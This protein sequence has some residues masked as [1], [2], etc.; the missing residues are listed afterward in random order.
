MKYLV[1]AQ[2][3]GPISIDYSRRDEPAG[4]IGSL[5]EKPQAIGEAASKEDAIEKA[6]AHLG[7]APSDMAYVADSNDLLYKILINRQYQEESNRNGKRQ[8]MAW[9]ILVFCI[10]SF[11]ATL[12]A[13]LG[14][15]G[16]LMFIGVTAVYIV[17]VLAQFQNE[18]ESAVVCLMVL[19]LI[20][21]GIPA[22]RAAR[23]A[24]HERHLESINTMPGR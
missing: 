5:K 16:F 1:Y 4:I 8:C 3:D 15:T 17:F 24:Y 14:F 11:L 22:F 13:G 20:C 10:V 23:Q 7:R 18:L 2:Q 19:L 6:Y 21:F 12:F 9:S